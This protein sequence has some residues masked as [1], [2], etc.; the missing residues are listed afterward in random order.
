MSICDTTTWEAGANSVVG[1]S[2][3]STTWAGEEAG[4]RVAV[5]RA[6]VSTTTEGAG[7]RITGRRQTSAW[8]PDRRVMTLLGGDLVW[9]CHDWRLKWG[10]VGGRE[11]ERS[12]RTDSRTDTVCETV[13]TVVCVLNHDLVHSLLWHTLGSFFLQKHERG[14]FWFL[15][16]F[17]EVSKKN[18]NC[19]FFPDNKHEPNTILRWDTVSTILCVPNVNTILLSLQSNWRLHS[20]C[21]R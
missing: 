13:V 1:R 7:A 15:F 19:K 16:G 2:S 6:S 11:E 14:S 12:R 4:A 5:G 21:S 8:K 10:C 18:K 9:W 3:V 17:S 20:V